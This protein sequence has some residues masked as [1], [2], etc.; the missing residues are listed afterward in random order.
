[1]TLAGG[2]SIGAF[3]HVGIGS[4]LLPGCGIGERSILGAGAV[5]LRSVPDGVTAVGVPPRVL[6]S[7]PSL[8]SPPAASRSA[9]SLLSG[10]HRGGQEQDCVQEAFASNWRAT[11]GPHGTACEQ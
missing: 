8:A 10:P 6:K 1:A 3:A 7:R 11:V 5:V 4:S 9:R 2:V